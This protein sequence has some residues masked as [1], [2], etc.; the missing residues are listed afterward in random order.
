M[1]RERSKGCPQRLEPLRS[2]GRLRRNFWLRT[3]P[4][5]ITATI[6][7]TNQQLKE[8]CLSFEK[9]R[10][11][12]EIDSEMTQTLKLLDKDIRITNQYFNCGQHNL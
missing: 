4:V 12:R 1:A 2:L 9:K 11:P 5:Q 8:L 6:W 7:G 3:S 10:K